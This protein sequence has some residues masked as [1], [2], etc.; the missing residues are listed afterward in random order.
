[1]LK[2]IVRRLLQMVP[3]IVGVLVV[4]F[5]LFNLVGGSPARMKLGEKA[6]PAMLE[7]FDEVRGFNKPLFWGRRVKTRALGDVDFRTG[8]GGWA[9]LNGAEW[10]NGVLRVSA[11]VRWEPP[12][13]FAPPADR[14]YEW[15][16]EWRRPGERFWRV[17]RVEAARGER[18]ESSLSR[19]SEGRALE[20]RSIGLRRLV[21]KPWDSQFFFYL[22]RLAVLDF[23]ISSSANVPVADLL[24]EGIGPTL[25]L[26]APILILETVLAVTL[27]LWSAYY[28]NRLPDRLMVVGS[29]ALMSINYLIWII[30]GQYWLAF[31]LGWFPVWGFNSWAYLLLPILIGVF[32][33][34]GSGV[35]FYRTV[36]LEEMRKEYVRTA[37]A[38]G[39]SRPRVLFAHVLR[40]ALTAVITQVA[41]SIPFLYTGSLLLESYFG[42]PG[43]GYLGV[44]AINESDIDVVRAIVV[45]GSFLYLIANLLADI[46]YAWADPRIRLS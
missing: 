1:M 24:K 44:N 10:T 14:A 15:R 5:I 18:P 3:T 29:V 40:N 17:S 16:I 38:K 21:D 22:S 19:W 2:F 36:L 41:L 42:I 46:C 7:A 32:S 4:T 23:G 8:P 35:R 30:A 12:Y 39:L 28:H 20:I 9:R 25:A 43:L 26:A 34:L 31:R 37:Y 45:V 33:G 27:G 6:S 11:D 13:A